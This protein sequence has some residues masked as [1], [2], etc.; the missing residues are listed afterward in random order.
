M[1]LTGATVHQGSTGSEVRRVQRL[2]VTMKL[3]DPHGID[4][5]FG[6]NTKAAVQ[7][8]QQVWGLN[9]DGIVGPRT[10]AALPQDPNTP[11]LAQGFRGPAVIALQQGLTLFSSG[12]GPAAVNP[13]PIDGIFGPSTQAAVTAYQNDRGVTP[14]GIVGDQT[15]WVPAGAAGA[16]LA[17]ISGLL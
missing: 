15:W 1:A 7:I 17:S 10:W 8:V 5:Q 14:D 13:G 11:R 3:L 9:P 2:L 4:G 6:P 16:T 12:G